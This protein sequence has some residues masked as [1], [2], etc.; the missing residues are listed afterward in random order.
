MVEP[1]SG[2]LPVDDGVFVFPASSAQERLWFLANLEP[3]S[4]AYNVNY[5]IRISGVLRLDLLK[6]ALRLIVERHESLRT[7]F[8][9]SGGKT[10]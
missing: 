3:A 2:R 7:S 10:V 1:E 4:P 6:M 9:T 8:G 5:A